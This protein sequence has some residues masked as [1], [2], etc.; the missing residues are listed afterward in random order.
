MTDQNL[1]EK[2]LGHLAEEIMIK[3][4]LTVESG[5]SVKK[6]VELMTKKGLGC[7]VVRKNESPVGI[8]TER[9]ILN[10]IT[11]ENIDPA[12]VLIQ[13]IMTAPLISVN[14]KSSITE[15]AEKMDIFH[16]RRTVVVDQKGEMVGLVMAEDL[17]SWLAK[18]GN[19]DPT[20]ENIA[21]IRKVSSGPYG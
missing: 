13:D 7:L 8:V 11:A 21:E 3:D 20:F 1:R 4:I 15:I 5:T 14:V 12:R 10:K 2:S 6:A 9:D 18:R 16:V 19:H 17:T